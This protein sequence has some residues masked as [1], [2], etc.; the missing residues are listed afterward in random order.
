MLRAL[1]PPRSEYLLSIPLSA[2]QTAEYDA[3]CRLLLQTTQ[4]ASQSHC[5]EAS[6]IETSVSGTRV[7]GLGT[8][9]L[10]STVQWKSVLPV[11]TQ[12]RQICNITLSLSDTSTL[13]T[14]DDRRQHELVTNTDISV[15][16]IQHSVVLPTADV[17]CG[18]EGLVKR[19]V[20]QSSKMQ[21]LESLLTSVRRKGNR[22]DRVVVVSNFTSVLDVVQ[23]VCRRN[24][25]A[26]LRIDGSVGADKRTKIVRHFN[27]Y[28]SN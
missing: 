24:H 18:S 22:G 8:E 5:V 19:M 14:T 11:L 16:L 20:E 9:N 12:L 4:T 1:L 6:D 3:I 15:N 27:R 10:S 17:D 2:A 26:T 25:W 28:L 7:V 21:L 23:C 13:L